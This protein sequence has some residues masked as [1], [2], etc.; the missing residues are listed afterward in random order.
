[1]AATPLEG[2]GR[3]RHRIAESLATLEPPER[4]TVSAW[5]AKNIV[6]ERGTTPDPGEWDNGRAPYQAGMMNAVCDPAVEDVVMMTSAQV[7]KTSLILNILGYFIDQDPCPMLM[8][9][10]TVELGEV[11]SKDR[12]APMLRASPTL[13]KK[14]RAVRSRD[15]DNTIMHKR[16]AGGA[17]AVVGANAA[18]GLSMRPVRGVLCDEVDRFPASAGSEGDPVA[19]ARKRTE[20]YYNRK[21]VL[22]STPTLRGMSRIEE[23]Y[24]ESDQR[25]FYVPCPSCG[26]S[27]VLKFNPDDGKGGIVY[28]KNEDGT[29]DLESV[30]YECGECHAGIEEIDKHGMLLAGEWRA[31][32]EG[33]KAVGF[34]INA[35]YSP[36]RRWAE[37]VEEWE[38]VKKNPERLKVF[39]NTVLGE[40]WEEKGEGVEAGTLRGRTEKYKGEVPKGVGA[41]V[42]AADVQADR[43]EWVVKGFGV[44]DE[45]WLIAHDVM[46]GDPGQGG[47]WD[48]FDTYLRTARWTHENGRRLGLDIAVI[49][50]SFQTEMVYR[51]TGAREEGYPFP[52]FSLKGAPGAREVVG[53]PSRSDRYRVKFYVVGVDTAKDIVYSRLRTSVPGPGYMH[54]PHWVEDEYLEQLTAERAVRRWMKGRGWVRVWDKRRERN[55]GLDVEVYA[56]AGIRILGSALTKVIRERADLF[57][58]PVAGAAMEEARPTPARRPQRRDGWVNRWK[59]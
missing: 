22:T 8:V 34:H 11:W 56:L 44:G 14:V 30:R 33:R 45:S 7:G 51:F 42:L 49:D 52:V 29:A 23:A 53:K 13:R 17:L 50:S 43:L 32:F 55:E 4:L 15:S 25:H 20:N 5:A 41:L 35:L 24:R 21:V 12:L 2:I 46:A 31:T 19:L 47:L 37:I 38:T 36:W 27:Q 39:V 59:R 9:L 1:M 26:T 40:T 16:Y 10:P 6:L 28:G 54:L 3:L 57:A 18:S 48:K 58:L